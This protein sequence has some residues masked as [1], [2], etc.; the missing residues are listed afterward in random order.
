MASFAVQAAVVSRINSQWNGGSPRCRLSLP[1]VDFQLDGNPF[2]AVQFPVANEDILGLGPVGGRYY[3]EEGAIRLVLFV[4]LDEGTE[5]A[6]TWI[7]ELRDLFRGAEF[8][9]VLT[10]APSPPIETNDNDN[11]SYYGLAVAIP[12]QYDLVG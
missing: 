10:L 9:G 12:Y 3:R 6:Q 1:N 11:G 8:D 7:N 5:V 4:S 2:L